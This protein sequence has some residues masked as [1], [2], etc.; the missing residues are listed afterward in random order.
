MLEEFI[1]V[2]WAYTFTTQN[3]LEASDIHS[4]DE[5]EKLRENTDW[6]WI[7]CLEPN[8]EELESIAEWLNEP[9][10]KELISESRIFSRYVKVN[11]YIMISIPFV[12]FEKKVVMHPIHVFAEKETFVTIRSKDSSKSINNTL[13]TFQDCRSK[14]ECPAFSPFVISRLFYEATNENLDV[15]MRLRERIDTIEETALTKPAD[16]RISKTVFALKREIS[17]L[18]R[19]LWA[20]RGKMLSIK[21]GVVPTVKSSEMGKQTLSYAISNVSRELSLISSYDNALDSVL[22]L[23]DLGMIHK[24]ERTL[25]Y[26]TFVTLLVNIVMILLEV[27]IIEVLTGRGA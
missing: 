23:Q 16:K 6:F 2:I 9:D 18:E 13:K 4:T 12:C 26:L 25:I 19:I 10:V 7:D 27:G 1:A 21:E 20:Q 17:T 11:E 22:S 24:V 5:L 15:A 3:K 8:D 14:L